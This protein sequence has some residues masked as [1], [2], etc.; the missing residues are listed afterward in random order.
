MEQW[1]ESSKVANLSRY[2]AMIELKKRVIP[3][4]LF[5]LEAIS[6]Q[7]RDCRYIMAPAIQMGLQLC[8]TTRV[9]P[10]EIVYGPESALGLEVQNLYVA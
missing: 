7:E 3:A 2:D 10:R 6:L 8:G 5:G 9:L 1:A 4:M